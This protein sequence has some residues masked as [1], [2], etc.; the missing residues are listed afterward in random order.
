MVITVIMSGIPDYLRGY[1]KYGMDIDVMIEAKMKERAIFR[2]YEKYP[3][4]NCK[5]DGT[6]ICTECEL[7][8][9]G[10]VH[11]NCKTCDCCE[12]ETKKKKKT[13]YC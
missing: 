2:L 13:N 7:P 1:H 6:M 12:G 10:W 5:I 4:M 8:G 11:K 9:A 3:E